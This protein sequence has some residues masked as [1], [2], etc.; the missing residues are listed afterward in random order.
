MF[1]QLYYE[2]LFLTPYF[3]ILERTSKGQ[4]YSKV[5][6]CHERTHSKVR[7]LGKYSAIW[8]QKRS[9][10]RAIRCS[11]GNRLVITWLRVVDDQKWM[12]TRYAFEWAIM[13]PLTSFDYLSTSVHELDR[14]QCHG[15]PTW[16]DLYNNGLTW[17]K[18][19]GWPGY[20]WAVPSESDWI[21]CKLRKIC[22]GLHHDS[23]QR[24]Q[25]KRGTGDLLKFPVVS[26]ERWMM[27]SQ[28]SEDL[29][30]SSRSTPFISQEMCLHDLSYYRS[31]W[32][33]RSMR[34]L[35]SHRA[36]LFLEL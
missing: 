8:D 13:F 1:H 7:P 4:Q 27:M 36:L 9:N 32:L 15:K 17:S 3:I 24:A 22:F 31:L 26:C 5:F 25:S 11:W 30:A 34:T 19:A 14:R 18:A 12:L 21:C 29:T 28:V 16:H 10:L 35:Q 23:C 6:K 33:C 20:A 2:R